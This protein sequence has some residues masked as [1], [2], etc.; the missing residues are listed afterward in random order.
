MPSGHTFDQATAPKVAKTKVSILSLVSVAE[1]TDLSITWPHTTEDRLSRDTAQIKLVLMRAITKSLECKPG[2]RCITF[3]AT[4][5]H[6][7]CLQQ[8]HEGIAIGGRTNIGS[9]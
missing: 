5:G 8:L 3:V 7:Q 4:R 6:Y 1:E 9:T 2:F